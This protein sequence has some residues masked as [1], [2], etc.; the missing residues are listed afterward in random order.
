MIQPLITSVNGLAQADLSRL[1][2]HDHRMRSDHVKKVEDPLK[3]KDKRT[4]VC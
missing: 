1:I 4:E 2:S 3:I